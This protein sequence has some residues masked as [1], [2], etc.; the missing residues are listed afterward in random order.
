LLSAYPTW[1]GGR[2]AVHLGGWV[3]LALLNGYVNLSSIVFE[4]HTVGYRTALEVLQW[5][6]AYYAFD[7]LFVRQFVERKRWW[8]AVA[9]VVGY[10]LLQVGYVYGTAAL[11]VGGVLVLKDPAFLPSWQQFYQQGLGLVFDR[12]VLLGALSSLAL[13]PIALKA[14]KLLLERSLR[15]L[16]A[17]TEA[18]RLE[19]EVLKAQVSPHF[20]FNTLNN[21]Y[22]LALKDDARTAEVIRRLRALLGYVLRQTP[23]ERVP[24]QEEIEFIQAYLDLERIRHGKRVTLDWQTHLNGQETR[25][26]PPLLLLPFVENAVKHGLNRSVGTVFARFSVDV[27]GDAFQF[28]ASNSLPTVPAPQPGGLGLRN[29]RQRLALLYPNRHAL[30]VEPTADEFRVRLTLTLD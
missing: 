6:L 5:L 27:V 21:V 10:Y 12:T 3:L 9:F 15:R 7:G 22:A 28:Q 26:I 20:L 23:V 4:P 1:P 8:G 18:T 19:M 17:Q 2:L 29:V 30:H 24:I 14:I 13:L 11:I 16:K 25:L